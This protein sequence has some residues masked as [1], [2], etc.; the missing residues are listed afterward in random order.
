MPKNPK[1]DGITSSR[2][3]KKKNRKRIDKLEHQVRMLKDEIRVMKLRGNPEPPPATRR[4]ILGDEEK[5]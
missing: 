2:I 4:V 3:R 5:P 1:N